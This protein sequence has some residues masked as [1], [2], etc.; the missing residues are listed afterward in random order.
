M[1]L[2]YLPGY[3]NWSSAYR[4]YAVNKGAKWPWQLPGWPTLRKQLIK[5]NI[6]NQL[7]ILPLFV[8][9]STLVEVKQRFDGF[10]SIGEMSLQLI[11]VYYV[12]DFA[13]YWAHRLFHQSRLLY[14]SHKVHH[15][16][17]KIF[18]FVAQYIHPVDY[19]FGNMVAFYS[20]SCLQPQESSSLEAEPICSPTCSGFHAK[21]SSAQKP[22]QAFSSHGA[23]PQ[24][25]LC[26]QD[27]LS[28]TFT[29]AAI[30]ATMLWLASLGMSFQVQGSPL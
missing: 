21:L 14:Q 10:P 9:L 3:M 16:Y 12:D 8:W 6:V 28:T 17:G 27:L 25:F 30:L 13:F 19:I 24:L 15:Q 26:L 2:L 18:T 11:F 1:V 20:L 29:I 23:Q 5:N 22:T 4:Q 7:I